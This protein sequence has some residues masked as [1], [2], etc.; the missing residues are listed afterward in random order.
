MSRARYEVVDNVGV[1][2]KSIRLSNG[3]IANHLEL[4][5]DS[6]LPDGR[7][8]PGILDLNWTLDAVSEWAEVKHR[9]L[10]Q[11]ATEIRFE[12]VKEVDPEIHFG[13]ITFNNPNLRK[14]TFYY[15][16]FQKDHSFKTIPSRIELDIQSCIIPQSV[17]K[18][19]KLPRSRYDAD[20][21]KK[22]TR[23]VTFNVRYDK[24]G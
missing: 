11:Q 20:A 19:I 6:Q 5:F 12:G 16:E 8:P 15:C 21:D 24:I 10:W 13:K 22:M 7:D 9:D 14:L 2:R 23:R 3:E 17:W 4:V 18:T 1:V